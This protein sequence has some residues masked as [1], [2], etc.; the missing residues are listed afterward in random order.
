MR[1][2]SRLG[3]LRFVSVDEAAIA[4]AEPVSAAP[5][6]P[7]AQPVTD[8]PWFW[9]GVILALGLLVPF[10]PVPNRAVAVIGAVALTV[11]YV[12]AVVQFAAHVTRLQWPLAKVLIWLLL[13]VSLWAALQWVIGPA[14]RNSLIVDLKAAKKPPSALQL[15]PLVAVSTIKDIALLSAAMMGG[16]LVARLIDIWGVLFGGL[17]SQ[18]IEKTPEVAS[19]AMTN[20]PAVGALSAP[21]YAVDPLRIGAGDYLF[22]GL[23][24]AALHL[25]RMNWRGALK[26]TVLLVSVALLSI[27]L[28]GLLM[29]QGWALPGLFFIGLGVALPNLKHFEYT[30]EEKF[31]LLYAAIFV[32]ILT[33]ALYFGIVSMLPEKPAVK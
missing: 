13:S 11:V 16:S 18:M 10:V 15:A 17:V 14:L 31:A 24:F 28:S 3:I 9:L 33:A 6:E 19:K 32:I 7:G 22:L 8:S 12:A 27:L 1:L 21:Q 25:N 29:K 23:L 5:E 30:R 20:L 2:Q 4:A 26:L